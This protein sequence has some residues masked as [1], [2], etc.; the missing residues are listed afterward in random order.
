MQQFKP[1]K[2]IAGKRN[3]SGRA[4][5]TGLYDPSFEH[6]SCGVGFI[7][8][9]DG[10]SRHA[11]VSEGLQV[12]KNLQHR[13]AVGGDAKTGDGAGIMIQIPDAF[14]KR[15]VKTFELPETG[16]YAV[17]M[18]FLPKDTPSAEKCKQAVTET[19]ASQGFSL[20]GWRD[21]PVNSAILGELAESTEPDIFQF[22]ITPNEFDAENFQRRL[23]VLRRRIEQAVENIDQDLS[24]FYICSL[25]HTVVVYKGLLT[26]DQVPDYF[27]DLTNEYFTS[28]Y[29]IVHS[30][31]STN[32]LPEWRLAQPFRYLAHNGEINTIRGNINR[33][34]AREGFMSS[35][36]I[37]R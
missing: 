1:D 5:S 30:R 36:L 2:I 12:L 6:D 32:T 23:Y 24:Q 3:R 35:K 11:I 17:G 37:G 14:F 26:G 25:S 13:G 33:Q 20:L 31:F 18:L 7:A 16:T 22:F 28:P 8:H 4:Y 10:E 21:V 19:T 29:A 27:P 34:R 9:L 15:Q